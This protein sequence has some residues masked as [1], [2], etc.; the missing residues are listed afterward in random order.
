MAPNDDDLFGGFFD[1]NGDGSTD[2]GEEY[3]AYEVINDSIGNDT[4]TESDADADYDGDPWNDEEYYGTIPASESKY[5]EITEANINLQAILEE[6]KNHKFTREEYENEKRKFRKSCVLSILFGLGLC[7]L[8]FS[9]VWAAVKTYDPDAGAGMIVTI[10]FFAGG[11]IL[12]FLILSA[13]ISSISEDR[14]HLEYIR[15]NYMANIK[16][17]EKGNEAE[18]DNPSQYKKKRGN[19]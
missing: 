3:I 11:L 18:T 10:V 12:M 14:K 19:V 15:Q 13:M 5:K 4:D 7:I 16:E 6:A 1:L 17:T 9:L 8:A 2:A